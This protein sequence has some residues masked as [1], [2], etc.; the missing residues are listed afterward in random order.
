MPRALRVS[1]AELHP[2]QESQ[3]ETRDQ[4][5]QDTKE[6]RRNLQDQRHRAQYGCSSR[7]TSQPP[8][9]ATPSMRESLYPTSF[10][11]CCA[12]RH[13]PRA[14]AARDPKVDFVLP[15]AS[16]DRATTHLAHRAVASPAYVAPKAAGLQTTHGRARDGTSGT[17]ALAKSATHQGTSPRPRLP[18]RL[19][20]AQHASAKSCQNGGTVKVAT[21]RKSPRH[22]GR[23]RSDRA[24]RFETHSNVQLPHASRPACRRRGRSSGRFQV[25]RRWR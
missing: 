20:L 11:H 4:K 19:P 24:E 18:L 14:T 22:F 7:A 3:A 1:A 2:A 16:I 23:A 17:K 6:A 13:A 5:D 8:L 12:T 25:Q 9:P 15:R 10:A 21:W